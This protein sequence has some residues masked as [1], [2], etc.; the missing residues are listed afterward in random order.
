MTHIQYGRQFQKHRR[1][2][3]DYLSKNKAVSYRPIQLRETGVLL[4]NLLSDD[5]KRDGFFRRYCIITSDYVLPWLISA[6][7]IS[8]FSTTVIMRVVYGHQITSEED[9]YLDIAERVGHAISNIGSPGSTPVDFFPIREFLQVYQI[10][11]PALISSLQSNIFQGGFPVHTMQVLHERTD[12]R[13]KTSTNT[14]S[15]KS[16]D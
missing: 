2:L 6:V 11:E 15:G 3:Q 7:P 4:Q 1:L 8:R 13:L 14:H 10:A 9:P 12:L 5:E 16:K